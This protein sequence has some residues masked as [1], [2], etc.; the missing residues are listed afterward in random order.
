MKAVLSDSKNHIIANFSKDATE[1]YERN[2]HGR[3]ITKSTTGG[4]LS[5]RRC[6]LVATKYGRESEH[7]SL[8]ITNFE[9]LGG[10]DSS[11][12]GRPVS[13]VQNQ[14]LSDSFQELL[15]LKKEENAP[16]RQA[17]PEN[18]LARS[19]SSQEH[20]GSPDFQTQ[21]GAFATQ[22]PTA[23]HAA[24]HQRVSE[25]IQTHRAGVNLEGPRA[26]GAKNN[27]AIPHVLDPIA[28][29]RQETVSI[30]LYRVYPLAKRQISGLYGKRRGQQ[31]IKG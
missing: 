10:N 11:K 12:F 2:N 14:G 3:R 28:L 21:S 9:Y 27:I 25:N 31:S 20:N 18:D 6:E 24:T 15:E 22:L 19:D 4:L 13:I 23:H 5:I 16:R 1:T 17:Q 26:P 29:L 30:Y 8:R 7:L